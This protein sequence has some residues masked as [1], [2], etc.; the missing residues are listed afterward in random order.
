MAQRKN[1][2]QGSFCSPVSRHRDEMF[3]VITKFHASD[4]L[5]EEQRIWPM[6]HPE[7]PAEF[8]F[9]P[10]RWGLVGREKQPDVMG[11]KK[12]KKERIKFQGQSI[13]DTLT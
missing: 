2:S 11:P 9:Q 8:L 7:I 4:N 5:C 6:S 10:W 13:G 3:A 1:L 12:L